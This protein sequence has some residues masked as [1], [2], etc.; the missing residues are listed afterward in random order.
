MTELRN[1]ATL[2]WIG[3]ATGLNLIIRRLGR[4]GSGPQ[5]LEEFDCP[6]FR[7]KRKAYDFVGFE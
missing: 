4:G 7:G 1:L 2:A 5:V 3:F 6:V